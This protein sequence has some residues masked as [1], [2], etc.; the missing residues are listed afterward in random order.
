MVSKRRVKHTPSVEEMKTEFDLRRQEVELREKELTIEKMAA[1]MELE[2]QEKRLSIQK[3]ARE[4]EQAIAEDNNLTYTFYDE[5]SEKSVREC[6]DT[7]GKISRRFPKQPL[8][9]VLNSPG[10]FVVDGFAL[11]DYI[12]SLSLQGHHIT[13]TCL[14]EAA[15]MGGILLQSGNERVMGKSSM[16]MIHEVKAGVYGRISF[17]ED[18]VEYAK[19]LWGRCV[20]ILA[21]RS[22]YDEDE[23]R[24]NSHKTDWWLTAEE[25]L[26]SKFVDRL[27]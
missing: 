13:V 5:V 27:I 25:A 11:Y 16:L 12:R 18:Q 21:E 2:L 20:K 4:E 26:R 22:V 23:I 3:M 15:S 9:L 17:M 10:G 19:L 24:K 14:G 8:N 7:L 1:E 6:M